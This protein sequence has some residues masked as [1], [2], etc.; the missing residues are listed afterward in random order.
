[1]TRWPWVSAFALVISVGAIYWGENIIARSSGV[2]TEPLKKGD[3]VDAVYGIGTVMAAH[4]FSIKPGIV[5][6]LSQVFVQEGD[7][8]KK[9]ARLVNV[10]HISYTA[11]F[12][13]VV[14]FL[15][16]KVGENIF[17]QVPAL[18]LTNLLDRYMVVTLEQVGSL[19]VRPG[20]VAKLSFDSLRQQNFLGKVEAVY[21]YN[22][23]FLARIAIANLPPEILPDMT[24]DVGI[25][26]ADFKDTLMIPAAALEDGFVWVHGGRFFPKKV[27][28]KIGIVDGMMAQLIEGDVH[29]GDRLLIHTKVKP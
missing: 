29:E 9:G 11:P 17:A 16:Y 3:L 20:Q 5:G 13:G 2:L 19:R 27:P 12:D 24:A 18:V 7:F 28:V 26:I 8:V 22:S 23:N 14:N 15:P 25:I 10:D 1:M 4:S 6:S 21:S